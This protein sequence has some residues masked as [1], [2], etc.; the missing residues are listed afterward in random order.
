MLQI[1]N[2]RYQLLGYEYDYQ[3]LIIWNFL[4]AALQVS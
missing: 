1:P 4:L 3:L 2:Y